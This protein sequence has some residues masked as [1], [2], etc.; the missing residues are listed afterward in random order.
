MV[1]PDA[2]RHVVLPDAAQ[3]ARVIIVGDIHGCCD[4]FRDLLRAVDYTVGADTL[5][6]VGD[7][8]NKGPKSAEVVRLAREL[9]CHA[10]LGNHELQALH[11]AKARKG[12]ANADVLKGFAWTDDLTPADVEFLQHLPYTIRLPLH[13]ALVV[14]AG[15]LPAVAVAE[16]SPWD[17]TTMRNVRPTPDDPTRFVATEEGGVAWASAWQGPEHVYFGHDA[18]R[19]LQVWP[20]ATGLDTGGRRRSSASRPGRCMSLLATERAACAVRVVAGLRKAR[21]ALT[22]WTALAGHPEMGTRRG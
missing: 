2:P 5:I 7:L 13:N 9:R 11:G 17:M 4:E 6:L 1:S 21:L 16:Q 12:G 19:E 15:L 8:V 18:K 20:H 3:R 14:H 10:I 22:R